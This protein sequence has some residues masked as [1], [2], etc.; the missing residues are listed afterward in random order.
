MPAIESEPALAKPPI[1]QSGYWRP[2]Q[3]IKGQ[4]LQYAWTCQCGKTYY[5]MCRKHME[6]LDTIL[7]RC[8]CMGSKR[9]RKKNKKTGRTFEEDIPIK[10]KF[11]DDRCCRSC[12]GAK[13]VCRKCGKPPA[14]KCGCLKG[15]KRCEACDG[16][17]VAV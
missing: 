15:I 3:S 10:R 6:I 13:S 11:L 1:P 7:E 8:E 2:M 16:S 5:V 17:G 9:I 14:K 12:L 4:V